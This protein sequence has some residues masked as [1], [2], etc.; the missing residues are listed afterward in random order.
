MPKKQGKKSSQKGAGRKSSIKKAKKKKKVT[1]VSSK[2]GKT[3]RV[4]APVAIART[5]TGTA[6]KDFRVVHKELLQDVLGSISYNGNSPDNV[7]EINP[8][9][10]SSFPWLGV[11]AQNFEQ[12]KFNYLRWEY[13][14][15]CPTSTAGSF[16]MATSYDARENPPFNS[17]QA[18]AAY[19]NSLSMTVWDSKTHNSQVSASSIRPS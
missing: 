6:P 14:P 3:V 9:L 1:I 7:Y 4:A 2:K 11:I 13:V 8:G 5:I 16:Y 18:I 10:V 12:Y 19:R 17:V 15:R